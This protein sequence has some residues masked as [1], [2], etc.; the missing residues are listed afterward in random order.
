MKIRS[1]FVSNSSTS[2]FV[3]LGYW[4]DSPEGIDEKYIICNESKSVVG[5]T[6][7]HG[8][9]NEHLDEIE[10]SLPEL[11]EK[12]KILAEKFGKEVS[13]IKLICGSYMC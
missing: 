12:A 5:E 2:S 11:M 10:F 7:A 8:R 4:A 13:E 9:E 6:L 3:A 1:G